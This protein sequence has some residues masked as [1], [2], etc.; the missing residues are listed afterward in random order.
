MEIEKAFLLF[1]NV[2]CQT[3]HCCGHQSEYYVGC[4]H[5]RKSQCRNTV[6]A[7]KDF[8]GINNPTKG[9]WGCVL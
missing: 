8:P 1:K 9:M 5:D 4:F 7:L 2:Q 3:Q 6:G